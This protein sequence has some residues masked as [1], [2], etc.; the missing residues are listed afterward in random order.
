MSVAATRRT[1]TVIKMQKQL[2][3]CL[4]STVHELMLA[5]PLPAGVTRLNLQVFPPPPTSPRQD[6]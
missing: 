2:K 5:I 1:R 3:P 4:A 6:D